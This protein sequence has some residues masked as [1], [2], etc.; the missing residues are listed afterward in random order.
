MKK[1]IFYDIIWCIA[2]LYSYTISFFILSFLQ[3]L[4]NSL[5]FNF[6]PMSVKKENQDFSARLSF[7]LFSLTLDL[8][9]AIWTIWSSLSIPKA[10]IDSSLLLKPLIA[11][12]ISSSNSFGKY[13]FKHKYWNDFVISSSLDISVAYFL[14]LETY[15]IRH[16]KLLVTWI[17]Y[18]KIKK[19]I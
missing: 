4:I 17:F 2:C 1:I 18:I 9:C 15:F 6:R 14:N 10:S 8:N 16:I 19:N 3:F 11:C 12:S 7:A 5:S 13:I